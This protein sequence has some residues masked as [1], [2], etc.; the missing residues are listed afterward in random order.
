MPKK[1]V[2]IS[3]VIPVEL[4]KRL[5]D[6]AKQRGYTMTSLLLAGG[7]MLADF[8]VDFLKEME[9]FSKRTRLP[10]WTVIQNLLTVYVARDVALSEIFGSSTWREAFRFD[11]AGIISNN[12]LSADVYE[13]TKAEAE[14]LLKR[15]QA[16]AAGA[17][18]E[19]YISRHEAGL[20]AAVLAAKHRERSEEDDRERGA[21]LS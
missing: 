17:E 10:I 9:A 19:T 4:K 12:R 1:T 6:V 8:D 13:H 15:L 21:D 14:S 11:D 2:I 7:E 18:K 20:L 3:L 5:Q 16:S